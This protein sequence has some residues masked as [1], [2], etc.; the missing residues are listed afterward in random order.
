MSWIVPPIGAR[1]LVA[2]FAATLLLSACDSAEERAEAHFQAG[3][4]HLEAGDVERALVEF[5]NV[6]N[7]NGEHK[8]ARLTFARLERERGNISVA[9]GQ[10]LRLVEQYPDNL[11]GHR[12]LAEMALELGNWEDVR[13]HGAVAGTLAPDDM[14]IKSI[15]NMLTYTDAVRNGDFAGV[16]VTVH[17]ARGMIKSHPELMTAR[18]IVIDHLIR[19][20]D[21]SGV[22]QETEVAIATDPLEES[23]YGIRLRALQEL[24][25]PAEIEAF[26]KQM[27]VTFPDDEGVEQ[28]LV[29]HYIDRGN[30]DAAELML[31]A[32][33]DP[34]A[35]DH[36]PTQ[37][38]IAFLNDNRD[39]AAA[40]AE[41][42]TI[43][44]RNGPNTF[45]FKT[46]RAALKF[47]SG[48]EHAA[49]TEM[50]ALLEGAE[51][52]IQT[53]AS[54]VEFALMLFQSGKPDEARA[55]VENVLSEDAA[56]VGALKFKA[57]WLIDE[58]KTGD[59]IVLLREALGQAP[60]DPQLMTLMAQAHE[61]NGDRELMGEMLALAT[62]ISGNAPDET[63]RYVRF[64]IADGD[65]EIAERV[66][67]HALRQTPDHSELLLLLGE[68]YLSMQNWDRLE[69]VLLA[70]RD[71][72][73]PETRRA[74]NELRAHMLAAQQRTQELTSFLNELAADPEFGLPADIALIRLMLTKGQTAE[75]FAH[76]DQLLAE[77][78]DSLPIRLIKA[79]ALIG[80]DK[81]GEAEQLY[82]VILEDYPTTTRAWIAL[83][84]LATERNAPDQAR[85]ILTEALAN[86]PE[87]PALLMLQAADYERTGDLDQA[88]ATYEKLYP[89]T[90]RSLIVVN[91]LASLLTTHRDDDE[92]LRRAQVLAQRLRG[93]Q[94]PVFQETYGWVA[95]RMGNYEEAVTYL[96]SAA[97]AFP[98]HPLVLYHLGKT[99][100][101]LSRNE[102]A[103]RIFHKA[104]AF[105]G[106][107]T[108][109]ASLVETEIEQL[110]AA[111]DTSH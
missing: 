27:A 5:R 108:E 80:E 16:D 85:E 8:E 2:F 17:K 83:H 87:S 12:N 102:D 91:N 104:R 36:M 3:L 62:E 99:Y 19:D 32:E 63:L 98:E 1:L 77:D 24:D 86:L 97:T 51:R 56:Q 15:N 55:L 50:R 103:L 35:E 23:L 61:R 106:A 89:I 46:V 96:E 68:V 21:W 70:I 52:N 100:A 38:L 13:R 69:T 42:D 40:I 44:A 41:L 75:A 74:A 105:G 22:L 45:Q 9:Y 20:E 53:R 25:M 67:T 57:S 101:A 71:L 64:L 107:S 65:L 88:I 90:N 54:E 4:A 84:G 39:S 28:L 111:S 94:E 18:Q 76:L 60:R 92:S 93:T 6:F 95:Y 109:I 37:R 10:Y 78:P 59:A 79:R 30:L 82:R 7:L 58:D 73:S 29:Q 26:L 33:V 48:D 47:R 110:G 34:L 11:E 81:R 49:I 72:D 66:L 43:I 14:E 31:R